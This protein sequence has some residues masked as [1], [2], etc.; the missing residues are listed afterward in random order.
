MHS[1]THSASRVVVAATANLVGGDPLLKAG[2]MTLIPQ[3]EAGVPDL[4]E[5]KVSVVRELPAGW[6]VDVFNAQGVQ[7][8]SGGWFATREAADAALE[9]FGK[10]IP[11]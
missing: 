10:T 3:N 9:K 6:T 4:A 1:R 5:K 8:L 7:V 11:E 2:V